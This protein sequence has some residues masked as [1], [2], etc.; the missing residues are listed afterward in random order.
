MLTSFFLADSI[1]AD[2]KLETENEEGICG[3]D[4]PTCLSDNVYHPRVAL[5]NAIN[6][7]LPEFYVSKEA[8][9]P[10]TKPHP[11]QTSETL[12]KIFR[13]Q[14]DIFSSFLLPFLLIFSSFVLCVCVY[15]SGDASDS[16]FTINKHVHE[17]NHNHKHGVKYQRH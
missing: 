3:E 8:W 14:N 7:W 17:F 16:D 5:K 4:A 2:I 1:S 12:S 15:F 6:D 13:L 11:I 9:G 10:I